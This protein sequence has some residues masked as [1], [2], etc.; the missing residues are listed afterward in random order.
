MSQ[1]THE[2]INQE[3]ESSR[4][5]LPKWV[6]HFFRLMRPIHNINHQSPA[7]ITQQGARLRSWAPEWMKQL[8][9]RKLPTPNPDFRLLSLKDEEL[10]ALEKQAKEDEVKA[11][12][13]EDMAYLDEEVLQLFKERDYDAKFQ[14]N[15]YRFFQIGY[16]LL[17]AAATVIG[18]ILAVALDSNPEVVP[19]LGFAET[20]VAALTTYLATISSREPPL[21]LWLENRRKAEYLRRE[22][23]RYLMDLS[24]YD[25]LEGY[26]RRRT[27]S[28]RAAN[29]NRGLFPDQE[30][31]KNA[32]TA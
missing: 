23:F 4:G 20:L 7:P 26:D 12:L 16:I 14:Q 11:R 9:Y 21:P 13:L 5:C 22:Y 1:Q 6:R 10:Q 32:P 24:P 8:P 3:E 27:L 30:T 18:A 15:R 25:D 29:I 31:I 19:W 2:P 17:A 28:T